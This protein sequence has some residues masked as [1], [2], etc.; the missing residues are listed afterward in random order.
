MTI[1][2]HTGQGHKGQFSALSQNKKEE[3]RKASSKVVSLEA[4]AS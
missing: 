4:V 2:A 3:E 1:T